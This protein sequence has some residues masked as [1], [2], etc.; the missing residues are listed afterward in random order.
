MSVPA[1]RWALPTP[2]RAFSFSYTMNQMGPG[3]FMNARG[4]SLV[5]AAYLSLG[6]EKKDGGVCVK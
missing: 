4:Q 5:D 2:P 3:L 1:A 6:Y